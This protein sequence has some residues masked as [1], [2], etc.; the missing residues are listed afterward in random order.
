ML[1]HQLKDKVY[2]VDDDEAVRDSIKLLLE[3]HG[4]D[5]EAFESAPNFSHCSRRATSGC[6]IL[7]QHMPVTT[8]LDFLASPEGRA[9]NIPV[10]LITGQGDPALTSIAR[11]AGAVA[12]LEKPV[13]EELLVA[14]VSQVI[15]RARIGRP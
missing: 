3:L 12:V 9:L 1:T 5:V 14:M 10:I 8:G 2:V 13:S 6:L 15:G 7:D 11:Q 4:Y